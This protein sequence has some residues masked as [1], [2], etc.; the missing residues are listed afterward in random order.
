MNKKLEKFKKVVTQKGDL[1]YV[2][3]SGGGVLLGTHSLTYSLTLTH[4]LLLTHSLTLT[5]SLLLTHSLIDKEK[6][7]FSVPVE[8]SKLKLMRSETREKSEF[9][10][11]AIHGSMRLNISLES[12][13]EV[14]EIRQGGRVRVVDDPTCA[15]AIYTINLL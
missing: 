5:H 13:E 3:G 15:G 12:G 2:A 4:S 1:V 14:R 9:Y 6:N 7:L 10:A 11:M 8:K